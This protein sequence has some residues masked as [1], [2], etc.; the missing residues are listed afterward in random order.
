MI[1]LAFYSNPTEDNIKYVI[2]AMSVYGYYDKF[3]AYNIHYL[4]NSNEVFQKHIGTNVAGKNIKELSMPLIVMIGKQDAVGYWQETEKLI[5]EKQPHAT[6]HLF[7]KS[8]HFPWIE[9]QEEFM[10]IIKEWLRRQ[11]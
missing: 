5:K 2:Q 6:I 10:R 9:E 3:D 4:K 8:A 7:N 1:K 11:K